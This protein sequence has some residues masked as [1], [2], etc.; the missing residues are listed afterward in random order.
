MVSQE[1]VDKRR[2]YCIL[3]GSESG[4][5]T[6]HTQLQNAK[7][8]QDK[9]NVICHGIPVENWTRGSVTSPTLASAPAKHFDYHYQNVEQVIRF[10]L[11]RCP[12]KNNL[13]YSPVRL[14]SSTGSRVY[15]EMHTIDWWWKRQSGL[16]DSGAQIPFAIHFMR[17][18]IYL[19]F[20]I[21]TVMPPADRPSI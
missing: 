6:R 12:L 19:F 18:Y 11:R 8:W 14:Y 15:A 21:R 10:L 1:A 4:P 3:P 7:Q 16:P 2:C 5:N 17:L 9:L 13:S 20:N